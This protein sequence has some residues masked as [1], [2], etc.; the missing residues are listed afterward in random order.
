MSIHVALLHGRNIFGRGRLTN[1]EVRTTL[2]AL[3]PRL[4]LRALVGQS[5]NLVFTVNATFDEAEL[6][7]DIERALSVHCV[8]IAAA[9][10]KTIFEQAQAEVG[11]HS[12]S[13]DHPYRLTDNDVKWEFGLLVSSEE[14]PTQISGPAE[15]FPPTRAATAVQLIQYRALLVRKRLAADNGKRIPWGD[16]VNKPWADHLRA[17]RVS[18]S[19]LTSRSLT[20]IAQIVRAI[21]EV[22]SV[23]HC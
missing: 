15:L 10:L 22:R 1:D 3:T 5:G 20:R 9:P 21:D 11:S 6:R 13:G 12:N 23:A 4:T 8:V 7:S 14:L 19:C 2:Q 18:M 17:H 16:A